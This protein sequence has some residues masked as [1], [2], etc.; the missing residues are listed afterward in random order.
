[1]IQH[2][3]DIIRCDVQMA[4]TIALLSNIGSSSSSFV[5]SGDGLD[6]ADDSEVDSNDGR[7]DG[8]VE[9]VGARVGG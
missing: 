3:N 6:V 2:R 9:V 5:D 1:M 7:E 8:A 4:M